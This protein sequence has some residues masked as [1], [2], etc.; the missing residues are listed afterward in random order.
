ML[1]QRHC[2]PHGAAGLLTLPP[3]LPVEP[4]LLPA[5]A[6]PAAPCAAHCRDMHTCAHRQTLSWRY[7]IVNICCFVQK[8]ADKQDIYERTLDMHGQLDTRIVAEQAAKYR[9]ESGEAQ[10]CPCDSHC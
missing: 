8:W 10:N 1:T 7:A 6:A 3:A 5:A 9:Q 4:L 2:G